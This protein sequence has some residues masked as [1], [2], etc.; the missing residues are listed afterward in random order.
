MLK[1]R[2]ARVGKRGHATF[3]IVVTEHTRPTKSGSLETLGS[4]DPHTNRVQLDAERV[5][6]YLSSGAQVSPTVH[7]L[8]VDQKVIEGAK[9]VARKFPKKEAPKAAEGAAPAPAAE[10]PKAETLAA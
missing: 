3:R 10:A 1:I 5:K 2:L 8:L 9:R 7:N 6:K 4:Y